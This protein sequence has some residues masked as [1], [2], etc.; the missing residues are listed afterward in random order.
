VTLYKG[1]ATFIYDKWYSPNGE[2]MDSYVKITV[3]IS[4]LIFV[5][6]IPLGMMNGVH[7][8][9]PEIIF[10]IFLTL[11]YY[12][13]YDAFRMNLPIFTLL[14]IGHVLH[15]TGIFGWYNISPVGWQW[16]HIT[17]IFGALPYA[18]LFFRFFEPWMDAKFTKKNFLILVAVFMAATGVG[19]VVELSEF[20]GY[21]QLGLGE[22]AFQFGPGDGIAGKT[23]NEL[24]D[25]IGGGWINEGWDFIYNT[26]GIII[27]MV[28]MIVI[29]A[30]RKR[31]M[32]IS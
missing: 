1:C 17:H 5:I 18:L 10:F 6:M 26:V 24:I 14:I 9:I 28:M 29:R 15:A 16:D 31:T 19:A 25:V 21:L 4:I 12:W 20:I 23:G 22:G 13:L 7:G 11:F 32:Q 2:H 8:F 30:I 27:G 3:I